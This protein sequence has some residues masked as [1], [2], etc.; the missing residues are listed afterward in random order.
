MVLSFLLYHND[1]GLKH[2]HDLQFVSIHF[3][4]KKSVVSCAVDKSRCVFH[5]DESNI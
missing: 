3:S 1:G 4:R 5:I 2:F